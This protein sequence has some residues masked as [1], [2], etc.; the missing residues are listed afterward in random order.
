MKH[1]I[2]TVLLAVLAIASV[3]AQNPKAEYGAF[4]LTNATLHT[5]TNGIIKNATVLIR[6]GKIEEISKQ[7]SFQED[8]KV[9]DCS[10]KH[11]F[12]G[13]IDGGTRL[14]LSEV[15]SVS[16]TQDYSEI[17]DVIPHMEALSA[18]NPNS[19]LIPVTR[20]SGVTTVLAAPS[21]GLFP[22][23]AS[24]IN[25][26]GYTPK[27]MFAGF[28]TPVLNFPQSGKRGWWDERTEEEINKAN[29]KTMEELDDIWQKVAQYHTID[30]ANAAGSTSVKLDYY[31]EM[32][33]LLPVYRQ[34][35]PLLVE[36]NK[37]KDIKKALEW[38]KEK[39]V[40][41]I[42]T[43][44]SEGFRVAEELAQ[45]GIPV[46]VGPV[47]STPSRDYDRFDRPYANPGLMK[48]AGVKVAIRT[49]ETENVRN[50]PYNAG[51]AAAYGMSKEDALKAITI[52]PA[53]LFD[54]ADKLG[55][56]EE[57]K[58]ATLFVSTGH[59]FETATDVEHVFID[60]WKIPMQ[61]RHTEL[62]EEFLQRSPGLKK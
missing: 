33:A 27:Q 23:K 6:D 57:G 16:L 3:Q 28:S 54:V 61:S 44:V 35:V 11:I 53:E 17:G 41:A 30:S 48:E 55:S 31:P 15:G 12:P 46:I 5:V 37:A 62:Y 49:M 56:I 59:P 18:V 7:T 20:V 52:V 51:F 43:G 22:G 58:Q 40:R 29:K 8:V 19:A 10:G 39:N 50:L 60:G 2:F 1:I 36:V 38:V 9:I 4:A 26:H 25:L 32:K 34:E 45:A 14:G 47:L 13:M 42:F 24:L 21:G